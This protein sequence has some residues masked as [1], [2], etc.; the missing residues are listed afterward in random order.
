MLGIIM[1]VLHLIPGL[2]TLAT[3][4]V[5]AAYN[6]K[7]AI[8][9]ARIGGDVSVAT[10]MVN[11]EAVAESARVR[12]LQAIAGSNALLFLTIGFAVPWIIYESKV[13]IWDNVLQW[14][15]TPPIK[16]AVGDWATTIIACLFGS[17]TILATGHMFFNRKDQP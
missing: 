14:G 6:A 8:T 12:G 7:V 4:W 10:T 17:N 3:G 2:S 1:T 11:A 16:G 5:T 9:T 13:V 15:S